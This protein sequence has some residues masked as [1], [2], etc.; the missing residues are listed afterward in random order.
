MITK[1]TM[2]QACDTLRHVIEE[3]NIPADKEAFML[4]FLGDL[5]SAS[6][7]LSRCMKQPPSVDEE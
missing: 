7:V 1:Q 2:L 4:H 3:A 6:R 5:N